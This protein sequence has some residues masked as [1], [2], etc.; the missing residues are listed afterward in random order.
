MTR[1]TFCK[2]L[3]L[4]SIAD[5]GWKQA[6]LPIKLG[7]FEMTS[8]DAITSSAFL[9]GWMHT[10]SKLP[11]R[12]PYL[13]NDVSLLLSTDNNSKIS[14]DIHQAVKSTNCEVYQHLSEVV[15]QPKK[16]QQKLSSQLHE[17]SA[18]SCLETAIS[19]SDV[20]AAKFRSIR[21]E[22]AESWLE[23]IPTEEILALKPDK[24][25]LAASLR[26]DIP[27]PLSTETCVNVAS[28]Q[29]NII[30]LHANME[31]GL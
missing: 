26:L 3:G 17:A 25:R 9:R 4:P 14:T 20:A 12:F 30:F 5:E 23:A 19:Q 31:V 13:T 29:M 6:T 21:G 22:E 27:A 24:F 1:R 10:L 18:N 15:K 28:W 7:R 11:T 8:V 16:L 2:I